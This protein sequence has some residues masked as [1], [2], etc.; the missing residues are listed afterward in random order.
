MSVNHPAARS[1]PAQPSLEHLK[2]QAQALLREARAGDA[3][4]KARFC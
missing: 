1:L 3:A 2:H 4:A